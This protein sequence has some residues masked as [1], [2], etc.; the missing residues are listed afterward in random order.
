MPSK[1]STTCSKGV[2]APRAGAPAA[3]ADVIVIDPGAGSG[4]A[5]LDAALNAATDGGVILLEAGNYDQ[6]FPFVITRRI[7]LLPAPGAGRIALRF[8]D[9]DGVA[10]PHAAVLRGFDINPL[11]VLGSHAPLYVNNTQG[12]AWLEDCTIHGGNGF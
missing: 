6:G 11:A 8:V 4:A 7:T 12:T 1:A 9:I 3:C 2:A 10:G 5:A